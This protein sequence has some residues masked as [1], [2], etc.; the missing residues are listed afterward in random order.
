[1]HL[2]YWNSQKV[3]VHNHYY[4]GPIRALFQYYGQSNSQFT[5][6]M[7]IQGRRLFST[8]KLTLVGLKLYME[9]SYDADT[10]LQRDKV[11]V[12]TVQKSR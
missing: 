5:A 9:Q 7:S 8:V 1:M 12:A 2:D 10:S 6:L 3:S 11:A 4:L